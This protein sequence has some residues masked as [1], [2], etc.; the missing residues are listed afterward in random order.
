VHHVRQVPLLTLG[1]V[2]ILIHALLTWV[3]H[4]TAPY[5]YEDDL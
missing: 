1:A 4:E 3:A 2:M 5:P